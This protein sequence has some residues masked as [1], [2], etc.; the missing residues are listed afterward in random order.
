MTTSTDLITIEQD[1]ESLNVRPAWISVHQ[2]EPQKIARYI[3]HCQV[4]TER[5]LARN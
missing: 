1:G 3:S 2:E 4:V 5:D